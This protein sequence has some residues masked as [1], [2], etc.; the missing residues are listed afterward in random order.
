[1]SRGKPLG[2]K[3]FAAIAKA[4]RAGGTCRG[5]AKQFK[6]SP[7]TVRRVARDDG[8]AEPFARTK[9]ARATEAKKID[10]KARRAELA[11]LLLE[12]C[13][14]LRLQLWEKALVY[15]FDKEGEYSQHEFPQPTFGDKRAIFQSVRNG[16]QSIADLERIDQGAGEGSALDRLWEQLLK[17]ENAVEPVAAK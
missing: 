9:T 16:V 17:E 13:H 11:H 7:D 3:E 10:N 12:D 8:I 1:M 6:R 14:R 5:I 15:N 4:I 2:D